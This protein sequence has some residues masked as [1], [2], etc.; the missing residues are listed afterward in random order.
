MKKLLGIAL[1]AMVGWAAPASAQTKYPE[2]PVTFLVPYAPGGI[3]DIAA[4]T[5]GEELTKLWGQQ[6]IVVNQ[7]GSSGYIGTQ[8]VAQSAP[9]G[10]TLVVVE[11]GVSIINELISDKVP[12]NMKNDF[13]PVGTLSNAPIVLAASI[14]SG[15]N[16]VGDVVAKAKE[17]TLVYASPATGTLNHLTVEWMGLDAGLKLRHVGY[18]GGSP[19]AIAVA[20]NEVPVGIL[21]LSS[22]R[23]YVEQGKAKLLAVTEAERIEME[24]DLPTLKESG[25][26]EIATTQ[27]TGLFAPAGT[28]EEI[29]TKIST[30]VQAVLAMPEVRERLAVGGALPM[31]GTSQEFSTMLDNLRETLGRV[32]SSV[33][34]E[35]K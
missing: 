28:P 19:A 35:K 10:Y 18:R 11:T 14:E 32:V 8:K 2:R 3:L 25:F 17:E 29:V 4:R 20:S 6:V 27:W 34:I 23:P 9:D 5:I 1:A 24:P 21:A 33:E 7:P 13:V 22:I 26:G 12:Y 16:S 31:P 15:Y 30:D